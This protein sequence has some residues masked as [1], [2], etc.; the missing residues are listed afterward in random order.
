MK[1]EAAIKDK[2]HAIFARLE[3]NRAV[4]F[5]LLGRVWGGG[6]GLFTAYLIVHH[7]SP[8]NQGYYYTFENLL[9]LQ[10]F[11]E[12]GLGTVIIQFA[13]HEW[14]RLHLDDTGKIA[15]DLQRLS[16]L[17]SLARLSVKWYIG[18]GLFCIVGLGLGGYLFFSRTHDPSVVWTGPWLFLCLFTGLNV[19][20]IPIWS[21]L[22]GCNQIAPVLLFKLL[23]GIAVSICVWV[24]LVADARLWISPIACFVTVICSIVFLLGKYRRFLLPLVAEK[25][26]QSQILWRSEVLPMQWRIGLTWVASYFV[27]ALFIPVLFYFKGA[28]VAGQYGMSW[29]IISFMGAIANSWLAPKVPLFGILIAQRK[30]QELDHVFARTTKVIVAVSLLLA[31]FFWLLVL[32]LGVYQPDLA[33]RLLPPLPFGVFLAA[34]VVVTSLIPFYTYLRAHKREP[35]LV[36]SVLSSLLVGSS[37]LITGKY[38]SVTAMALGFLIIQVMLCVCVVAVWQRCRKVWHAP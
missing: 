24:A 36:L 33:K 3:F 15:G 23:Q 4:L 2:L 14:S 21:L 12:L 35:L 30:F 9:M 38:F 19:C 7:L 22:E 32:V 17:S 27:F 18:V 34:Q 29:S 26:A 8:A 6:A 20:L 11:A 10:N 25:G 13:S 5:G 31:L 37:T 1:A 16:R 28:T